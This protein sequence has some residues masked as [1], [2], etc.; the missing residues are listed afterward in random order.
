MSPSAGERCLRRSC[1]HAQCGHL[2]VECGPEPRPT[3]AHSSV[4]VIANTDEKNKPTKF[5]EIALG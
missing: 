5:R 1:G 4:F 2:Q 3:Q